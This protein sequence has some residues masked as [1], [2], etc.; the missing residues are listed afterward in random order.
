ML[1]G[2]RK[3]D[4]Q[5]RGPSTL[6]RTCFDKCILSGPSLSGWVDFKGL[7]PL[8]LSLSKGDVPFSDSLFHE[9]DD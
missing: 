3:L 8:T 9:N 7:S 6:L 5:K 1:A 4:W 2:R